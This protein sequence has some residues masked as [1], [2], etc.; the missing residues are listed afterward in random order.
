MFSLSRRQAHAA[1][2]GVTAAGVY[3]AAAEIGSKKPVRISGLFLLSS[4]A[5][6]GMASKAL[7]GHASAKAHVVEA[8]LNHFLGNGGSL[9]GNLVVNGSHTV[10]GNS[11]VT[12]QVFGSGGNVSFGD[13]IDMQTNEIKNMQTVTLSGASNLSVSNGGVGLAGNLS[14]NNNNVVNGGHADFN[15]IGPGGLRANLTGTPTNIEL[16]DRCNFILNTLLT[17]SGVSW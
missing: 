16:R 9:G 10:N 5:M 15:Q 7:S 14:M 6:A 12:G 2:A 3:L 11:T 8:R 1:L 13:H 4:V 17:G